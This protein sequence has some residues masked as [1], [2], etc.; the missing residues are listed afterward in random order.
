MIFNGSIFIIHLTQSQSRKL[1]MRCKAT[2]S[3]WNRPL[4][5]N[6]PTRPT[7]DHFM[8][9]RTSIWVS[10]IKAEYWSYRN[11]SAQICHHGDL[12]WNIK[13]SP[14]NS[15]RV[16]ESIGNVSRTTS[17]CP[18]NWF[19]VCVKLKDTNPLW[20]ADEVVKSALYFTRKNTH[21]SRTVMWT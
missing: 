14:S 8:Y 10:Y 19:I 6:P 17:D 1:L 20:N 4:R 5:I 7:S 9:K 16:S 15:S 2:C 13:K 11:T 12:T 21:F 3:A 18:H